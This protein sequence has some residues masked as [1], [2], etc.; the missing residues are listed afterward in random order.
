MQSSSAGPLSGIRI[1]DFTRL[2]A[3]PCAT[4]LLAGMGAEVIKVESAEGDAMRQ[5]RSVDGGG[6]RTAPSFTAYNVMKSS[7]VL[8]LKDPTDLETVRN[9]CRDADVV[10]QA[11]RPGVMERLGLGPEA[12]RETNPRLV[13]GSLSAFGDTGPDA[14]RGGVDIVMQAETGLMS[15]TG[16]EGRGPVKVGLPII[17]AVS[18]YALALGIL[19]ALLQRERQDVAGDVAV[20]MLDAGLH[21][22]AQPV[23]EYLSSGR[24]ASRVGNKAPYAAPADAFTTGEGT[25]VLSA[26]LPGHWRTLCRL[27][28]HPEWIEDPRFVTTEIRVQHRAE[29]TALI[30]AELATAPADHWVEVLGGAGLTVG[31]IRDYREVLGSAQ[32]AANGSVLD[33]T[34]VDGT[35]IRIVRTPVRFSSFDDTAIERHVPGLGTAA[36]PQAVSA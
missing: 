5:A 20:S 2:I 9:L 14:A 12:L 24:I 33:A 16:E 32:V 36:V 22:Q 25:L 31:K 3:G 35:P 19:G 18:G 27:L 21:L 7:L 10:M 15:V 23:A 1:I 17:D 34:D 4:D 29:I 8:D 11:F 30:E 13:Y 6:S 26:H 28:G